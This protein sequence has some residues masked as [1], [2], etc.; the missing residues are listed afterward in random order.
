MYFNFSKTLRN[1]AFM[2]KQVVQC[3]L[4]WVL[5][6]NGQSVLAFSRGSKPGNLKRYF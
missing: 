3:R 1:Q 5:T 4:A 6:G 2:E